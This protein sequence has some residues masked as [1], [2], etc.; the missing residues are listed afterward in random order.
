LGLLLGLMWVPLL[1]GEW[2]SRPAQ[3]PQGPPPADLAAR[4]VR[5]PVQAPWA[6]GPE[7]PAAAVAG[8]FTPGQPG[9]G[10]VLLLHGVRGDRRQMLGRA[11]FLAG[12]GYATLMIDLPAHGESPGER[13]TFGAREA[14]GVR[15]AVGFL[16]HELPGQ[17]LAIIG[18]SLGGAATV[19]AGP[20]GVDA[21]VLE[22]VYGR[23]E[24]AVQNRL[25]MRLGPAGA[26]LVP[27]LL[28]P[29]PWRTGLRPE[30]L[31]PL[32]HIG[33]VGA[34]VLVAAGTLDRHTRWRETLGLY[35]AARPPKALWRVEGAAHVDLHSHAPA[36]Y[37][38]TVGAFLAEHLGPRRLGSAR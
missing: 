29:L 10:A 5:L 3:R 18:V 7:A 15:A 17:P 31:R 2:L 16:R 26:W 23:F 35:E 33:Q 25:T 28:W 36:A 19:L 24:D 12:Q 20:L 4:A 13:I 22:S 11:R 30:A 34:P 9:R 14:A 32:A 27:P 21:V 8:W 1:A 37:E 6:E 38:A